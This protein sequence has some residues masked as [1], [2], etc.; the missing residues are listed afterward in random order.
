MRM[1]IGCPRRPDPADT[2]GDPLRTVSWIQHDDM[3]ARFLA[4][5]GG[6][7]ALCRSVGSASRGAV[8]RS[9]QHRNRERQERPNYQ[10]TTTSTHD[11]AGLRGRRIAVYQPSREGFVPSREVKSVPHDYPVVPASSRADEGSSTIQRLTCCRA[12]PARSARH[13]LSNHRS[14]PR[15]R[16]PFPRHPS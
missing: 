8:L 14:P 10:E 13:G 7:G 15:C 1:R 9:R 16:A 5:S 4:S 11:A 6:R 2:M 3:S 12:P